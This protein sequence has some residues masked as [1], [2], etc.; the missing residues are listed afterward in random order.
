MKSALSIA[1]VA[2]LIALA[3]RSDEAERAREERAVIAAAV[4]YGG[5]SPG[6]PVL[7]EVRGWVGAAQAFEAFSAALGTDGRV[8]SAWDDCGGPREGEDSALAD[9]CRINAEDS[10]LPE[11]DDPVM[12]NVVR[13]AP[14]G[15]YLWVSRVGFSRDRQRARMTLDHACPLCGSGLLLTL[16]RTDGQWSVETV[17]LLWIS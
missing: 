11:L 1:I 9:W 3:T 6:I 15:Q 2:G 12:L 10:R 16:V 8:V 7:T 14:P 5:H 4:A 13:V 17:E